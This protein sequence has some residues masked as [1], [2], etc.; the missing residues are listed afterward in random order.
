MSDEDRWAGLS[1]AEIEA[2]MVDRFWRSVRGEAFTP[3]PAGMR[4]AIEA[5]LIPL[6][7][8]AESASVPAPEPRV[9]AEARAIV[10]EQWT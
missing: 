10:A 5:R 8:V 9:L 2:A 4:A 1:A 7:P 3:D 6:G